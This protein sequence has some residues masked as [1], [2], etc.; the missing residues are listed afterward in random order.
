MPVEVGRWP[1]EKCGKGI[2]VIGERV[3]ATFKGTGSFT[4][5]CPW[6]CGAWINRG[7]RRVRPGAL[8]V[9]RAEEFDAGRFP[10]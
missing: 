1:C 9:F 4:G 2:V 3:P 5:S 6:D 8:R 10:A 7:F